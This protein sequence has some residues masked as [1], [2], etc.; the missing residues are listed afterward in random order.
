[1]P[2]R[3]YV[4][5]R[6]LQEADRGCRFFVGQDFGVGEAAVVVDGDVDVLVADGAAAAAGLVD[7]ARV[8][9]LRAA[10]DTPAR[11]ALDPAELLDVDVQQ[12]AGP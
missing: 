2:W 3:R 8:V 4:R 9:V 5:G 1:M 11:A 7:P 10:A 6:S 12:L